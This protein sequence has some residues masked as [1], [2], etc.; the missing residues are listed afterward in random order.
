MSPGQS[1]VIPAAAGTQVGLRSEAMNPV[2]W[3]RGGA[4]ATAGE[5]RSQMDPGGRRGGAGGARGQAGVM[6]A[7]RDF[8]RGGFVV[9]DVFGQQRRSGI[10]RTRDTQAG[11][12]RAP[13]RRPA[14]AGPRTPRSA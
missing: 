9:N 2:P 7:R 6:P 4:G 1:H 3:P 12:P 14:V 10:V 5:A 8:G 11:R 13:A